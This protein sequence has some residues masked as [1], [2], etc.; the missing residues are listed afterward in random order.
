MLRATSSMLGRFFRQLHNLKLCNA[1]HLFHEGSGGR[2]KQITNRIC[3]LFCESPLVRPLAAIMF[4]PPETGVEERGGG[5][6][7][8]A[9]R[10]ML[11]RRCCLG[12]RPEGPSA[13]WY[14]VA[15]SVNR[16]AFCGCPD[17]IRACTTIFA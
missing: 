6:K 1:L 2:Y 7:D 16:G 10:A 9:G 12:K 14:Q 8:Q 3:L 5:F 15:V 17:K 13:C 11:C 4:F